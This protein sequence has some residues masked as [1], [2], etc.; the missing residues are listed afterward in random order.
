MDYLMVF[1]IGV[2]VGVVVG[3]VWYFYKNKNK[4]NNNNNDSC[5]GQEAA[6]SLALDKHNQE[7]QVKKAQ[8]E[9]KIMELFESKEK[10]CNADVQDLLKISQSSAT[11]YLDELEAGG[12]IRQVGKTGQSVFYTK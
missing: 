3:L 5:A 11:R 10:I 7:A 12:K 1:L 2:C 6:G 4:N 9:N 8:A